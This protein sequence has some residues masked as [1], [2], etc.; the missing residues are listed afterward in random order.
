MAEL[1]SIM[2]AG[3]AP[4][5]SRAPS[6]LRAARH[7]LPLGPTPDSWPG[8]DTFLSMVCRASGID[9]AC[10]RPSIFRRRHGACLRAVR[11]RTAEAAIA[12][13]SACRHDL[14]LALSALLIGVTAFFRDP[15]AFEALERQLPRLT[16]HGHGLKVLSVGCSDGAELYSVAM[17]LAERGLLRDAELRGIDCRASAVAAAS[18]GRFSDAAVES[19]SIPRRSRFFVRERVGYTAAPAL[20]DACTWQVQNALELDGDGP[21]HDVV[22]CRNLAIYLTPDASHQLWERL[23]RR[24]RPGGLLVTGKAERPGLPGFGRVG[25]CVF[26]RQEGGS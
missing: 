10:Y 26:M 24:V 19:L 5:G 22:L 18:S 9:P 12:S 15:F 4:S 11:A 21:G 25:P 3:S 2:F 13:V 17:L 8:P 6:I 16:A 1:H 23:G 14:E 20:R 7:E